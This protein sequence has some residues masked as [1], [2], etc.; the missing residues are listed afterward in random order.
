NTVVPIPQW[1]H[2]P[3]NV[4]NSFP[5]VQN[6]FVGPGISLIGQLTQPISANLVNQFTASFTNSHITLTNLNGP[7]GADL[8][9][10]SGLG[11]PG[12]PC[13]T[14]TGDPSDSLALG[15]TSCPLGGIFNNGFGGKAPAIVIGGNNLAYGGLGFTA[16]TAYTPWEHT[17]PTY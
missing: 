10:P 3:G 14:G 2:L 11:Q 4:V 16:D 7:G 15:L 8:S 1:Q 13:R 5:T 12:G 9:R 17:N 6:K